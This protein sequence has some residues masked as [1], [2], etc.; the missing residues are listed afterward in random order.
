M[1]AFVQDRLRPSEFE[2][3]YL[4]LFKND[5]TMWP[6]EVFDILNGLFTDVD[7]YTP[8]P[9]LRGP[10]DLDQDQLRDRTREAME[11]LQEAIQDA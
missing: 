7:A 1:E 11:K 6:Q 2:S 4:R 3:L 5:P 9:S 10:N 8:D